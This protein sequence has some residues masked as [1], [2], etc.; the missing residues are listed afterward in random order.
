MIFKPDSGL[1]QLGAKLITRLCLISF[2]L[3]PGVPNTTVVSQETDRNYGSFKTAFQI[4]LNKI[5]QEKM[6]KEKNVLHSVAC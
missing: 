1:G 3:Y 6:L 2:V 5:V 4:I